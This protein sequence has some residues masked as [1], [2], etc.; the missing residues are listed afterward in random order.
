[1][2]IRTR[3][4]VVGLIVGALVLLPL[5]GLA[6]ERVVAVGPSSDQPLAILL[7]GSDAG[8]PREDFTLT[9]RADGFQLLFVSADRQNA[10]IVS[11]PRDSWVPVPGFGETKINACLT[12][13]PENCVETVESAFDITIDAY[14]VTSMWGFADAVNEFAGCPPGPGECTRGITVDV[15]FTCTSQCG[16]LP[17]ERAG[18][19]QLNGYQALTYARVRKGREG[20]DFGRSQGQA[21]L[22]ALAHAE[23]R[24]EGSVARMMDALRILRRHSATDL[25]MPQLAR[26]GLDAMRLDPANVERQ[27]APSVV[28]TIGAASAVRL[29]PEAYPLIADAADNGILDGSVTG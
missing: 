28:A 27:L 20:G 14:F 4:I 2:T 11:I 17:I 1:V 10:T 29:L 15:A 7:L 16:G 12:R 3:R 8:P 9:G 24:A 5:I 19:Q 26:L 22:L 13:G 21:E 23:M 18:P 25:T 6:M